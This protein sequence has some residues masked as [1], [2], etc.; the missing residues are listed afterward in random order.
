[1]RTP[2]FDA[3]VPL[4]CAAVGVR[5]AGDAVSDICF[6]PVDSPPQPARH[7][8]AQR[9]VAQILAYADD[10][11]HAIDLPLAVG[12]SDFQRRVWQA[13][14][15]IPSGATRTYGELAAEVG[16]TAR[17]VGQACGDNRLPLA[18]PCHRVVG[19]DSMGGFAH[20]T[21]GMMPAVKRWLLAHESRAVFA[22]TST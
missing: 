21:D 14:S 6:L 19:A 9:A 4:P 8:L 1:M 3:I 18:I 22:L 2:A 15:R 13:I 17:A 5:L 7:A 16:G 20:R 10:P 11:A 12:G